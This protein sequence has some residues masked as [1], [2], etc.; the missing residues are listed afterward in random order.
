MPYSRWD[1]EDYYD[2]DAPSGLEMYVRHAAFVEGVELFGAQF[3]GISKVEAEAMTRSNA[4]C[5][6]R[7]SE[8]WVTL[9]TRKLV[10]W[11]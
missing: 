9:V 11:A 1:V 10:L 3:F 7:P 8:P 4:I 6:K 2:P 5:W